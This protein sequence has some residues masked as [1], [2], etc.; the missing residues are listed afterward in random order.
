MDCAVLAWR[1]SGALRLRRFDIVNCHPQIIYALV[2]GIGVPTI[3][4][5][6][7]GTHGRA[8]LLS[9]IAAFYSSFASSDIAPSEAKE[10]AVPRL[11]G[12]VRVVCRLGVAPLRMLLLRLPSSVS[13]GACGMPLLQ[14]S[15]AFS[16][17]RLADQL[18]WP[19]VRALLG[20]SSC[21]QSRTGR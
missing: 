8:P 2:G 19:G 4:Q 5:Y 13:A 12:V 9:S 10:M 18:T 3:F 6:C 16:N 1:C 7:S 11:D 15:L 14:L 20:P 21:R 17:E